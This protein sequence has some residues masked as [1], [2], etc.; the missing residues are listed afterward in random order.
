VPMVIQKTVASE[1][2]RGV[3]SCHN[4][5]SELDSGAETG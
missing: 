3:P 1:A 2:E 5:L 4:I